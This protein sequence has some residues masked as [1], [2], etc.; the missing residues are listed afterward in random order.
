M[1]GIYGANYDFIKQIILF[2]VIVQGLIIY[3]EINRTYEKGNQIELGNLMSLNFNLLI[4]II[5]L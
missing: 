1:V 4:V 5:F 3:P 2:L